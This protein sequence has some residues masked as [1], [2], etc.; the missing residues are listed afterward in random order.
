MLYNDSAQVNG[1]IDGNVSV[2]KGSHI[3]T[4]D[5]IKPPF[6]FTPL[7]EGTLRVC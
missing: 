3:T 2:L 4:R 5:L 6:I 7:I 1:T